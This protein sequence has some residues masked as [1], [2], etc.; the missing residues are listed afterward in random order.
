L[1]P[2]LLLTFLLL[3]MPSKIGHSTWAFL[4]LSRDYF[5]KGITP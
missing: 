1:I 4:Q 3:S 5:S 2:T